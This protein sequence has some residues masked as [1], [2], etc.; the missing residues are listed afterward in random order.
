MSLWFSAMV[1]NPVYCR[2][3]HFAKGVGTSQYNHLKIIKKERG[4]VRFEY[5]GRR[6]T[7]ATSVAITLLRRL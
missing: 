7:S 2:E 5:E 3:E 1:F 4:I 6:E